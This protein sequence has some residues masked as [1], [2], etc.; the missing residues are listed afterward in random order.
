MERRNRATFS[1]TEGVSGTA[2]TMTGAGSGPGAPAGPPADAG[3]VGGDGNASPG[4]ADGIDGDDGLAGSAGC[5]TVLVA[6]L[7]TCGVLAEPTLA[8]LASATDS[9]VGDGAARLG[10]TDDPLPDA[11]VPVIAGDDAGAGRAAE[12][13]ESDWGVEADGDAGAD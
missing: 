9:R 11:E 8:A 2:G 3:L 5:E 4:L 1:A 13:A 7:S 6:L 10:A 12:T